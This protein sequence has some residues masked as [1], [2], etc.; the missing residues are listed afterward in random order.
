MQC[1]WKMLY[2]STMLQKIKINNYN[3][4]FI[5]DIIQYII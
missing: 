2:Q 3:N 1:F 4:Y 5:E